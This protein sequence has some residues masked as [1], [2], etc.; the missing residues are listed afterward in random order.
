[1][2]TEAFHS[3]GQA[4]AHSLREQG[5]FAREHKLTAKREIFSEDDGIRM[6]LLCFGHEPTQNYLP[7]NPVASSV[8]SFNFFFIVRKKH[9]QESLLLIEKIS[10]YLD[11]NPFMRFRVA[12]K[13]YEMSISSLS[14]EIEFINQF[15]IAQQQPHGTVLFYKARISSI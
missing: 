13:N 11:N 8:D 1:M 9:Y 7:G 4:I 10:A 3:I 5:I 15:W 14:V 2:L 6:E 12:D